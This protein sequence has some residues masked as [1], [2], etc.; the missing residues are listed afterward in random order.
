MDREGIEKAAIAMRIP[1]LFHFTRCSNL[2]SIL[3]HGLCSVA[4]AGELGLKPNINDIRRL[5]GY[6]DAVSLSIAFP[7]DRMFF[8]Y[9]QAEPNE[10]W[11][12]L[13]INPAILWRNN[14]AFCERN[15]ADHRIRDRSLAELMSA[16][17]FHGMFKPIDGVAS[18]AEQRLMGCDPTDPQAEV[19]VFETIKPDE[20]IALGFDGQQSLDAFAHLLGDR[21]AKVLQRDKGLF[22]A[23]SLARDTRN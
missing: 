4:R 21:E 16:E 11:V 17:A 15:A 18:R 19:L 8:K 23:R 20:I 3:E 1:A 22:G 6:P 5:D 9:R 10:N 12:I 14:C 7:N 13:G 2:G